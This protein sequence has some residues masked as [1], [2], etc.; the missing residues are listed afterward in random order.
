VEFSSSPG[1]LIFLIELPLLEKLTFSDLFYNSRAYPVR[2]LYDFY[3]FAFLYTV[4]YD[5][6]VYMTGYKAVT[7]VLCLFE[8]LSSKKVTACSAQ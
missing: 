4:G 6:A 5:V 8:E 2:I 3:I 7:P 1:S